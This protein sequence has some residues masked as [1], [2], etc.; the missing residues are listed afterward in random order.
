MTVSAAE[1]D[2]PDVA[3]GGMQA[4]VALI[5][6]GS[7]N[8]GTRVLL[9]RESLPPDWLFAAGGEVPH[10]RSLAGSADAWV[11]G[12]FRGTVGAAARPLWLDT[13]LADLGLRAATRTG[14]A[15][16]GGFVSAAEALA[17]AGAL[18]LGAQDA[19]PARCRV[20]RGRIVA[21]A[22]RDMPTAAGGRGRS[23]PASVSEDVRL[24]ASRLAGLETVLAA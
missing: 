19:A 12:D 11:A 10:V 17:G 20:I 18:A 1:G 16:D 21:N 22:P 6:V 15:N 13:E 14:A 4:S 3:A 24:L 8:F 9:G 5:D 23:S 2:D 7:E